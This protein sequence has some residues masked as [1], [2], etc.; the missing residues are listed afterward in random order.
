[1]LRFILRFFG[2]CLMA[3]AFTA[4]VV[5]T[6]RSVS[7]GKLHVT[8]LGETLMG[9]APAKLNAAQIF[10]EHRLHPLVW[11]PIVADLMSMPVWLGI[12]AAGAF[13]AWL[14]RRPA[15]KFGFSSR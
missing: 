10:I 14:G 13:V 1:M 4:L 11:D 15:P 9:L 8:T 7:S 2:F 5:D 6:T 12:G 3:T